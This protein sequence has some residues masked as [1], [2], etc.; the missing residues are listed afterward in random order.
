VYIMSSVQDEIKNAQRTIVFACKSD[1]KSLQLRDRSTLKVFEAKTQDYIGV[2]RN[3]V[4]RPQFKIKTSREVGDQSLGD[5]FTNVQ[6]QVKNKLEGTNA[7]LNGAVMSIDETEDV[8]TIYLQLTYGEKEGVIDGNGSIQFASN[9]VVEFVIQKNVIR[10]LSNRKDEIPDADVTVQG[11][12]ILDLLKNLTG[13]NDLT[14]E[15]NVQ[16]GKKRTLKKR[17]GGKVSKKVAKKVTF[18]RLPSKKN[19]KGSSK[20]TRK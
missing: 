20:R 12:K 19:K 3:P 17:K 8:P 10:L 9:P 13:V 4:A 15:E 2:L 11:E 16:G 6:N 14:V 7:E 1:F 5:I 18:K